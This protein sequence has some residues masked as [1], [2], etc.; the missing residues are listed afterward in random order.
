MVGS[1]SHPAHASSA[2]VTRHF[3]VPH[4]SARAPAVDAG[5]VVVKVA[6]LDGDATAVVMASDGTSTVV[7]DRVTADGEVVLRRSPR[8]VMR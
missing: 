8:M 4:T 5:D 3:S 2:Q 6:G 1:V 7:S